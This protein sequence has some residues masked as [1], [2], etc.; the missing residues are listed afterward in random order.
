[1]A[2]PL[3]TLCRCARRQSGGGGAV[4]DL[5]T[6]KGGMPL[7]VQLTKWLASFAVA[8]M[9]PVG[10]TLLVERLVVDTQFQINRLPN[11]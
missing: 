3:D 1:M 5:K 10:E 9:V 7:R 4:S 6:P 11:R 2:S 8:D